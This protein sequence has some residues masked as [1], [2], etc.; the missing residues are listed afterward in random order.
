MKLRFT[1]EAVDEN[2]HDPLTESVVLLGIVGE[3][4]RTGEVRLAN[5]PAGEFEM[6]K[7]YTVDITPAE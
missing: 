2:P 5:A 1:C 6:G 7:A 3:T 4:E